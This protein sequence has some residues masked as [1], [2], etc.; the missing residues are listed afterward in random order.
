M[1]IAQHSVAGEGDAHS[2][3]AEPSALAHTCDERNL[4]YPILRAHQRALSIPTLPARAQKALSA[5]A[6]TVSANKPLASVFAHRPYLAK[7]AGISVRTWHRAENDLVDAGLI[8]VDE[9][10]RKAASGKFA[11]AYIYL[12]RATAEML[13][14]VER[15]EVPGHETQAETKPPVS[16]PSPCAT[17]A[18]RPI[19][20]FYQSPLSQKRQPGALP[21]D[22]E[23]LLEL[24]FNRNYIWKL[25]RI[26]RVEHGKLLG[27][28]VAVAGDLLRRAKHPKAY[29]WTLLRSQCDFNFL[30]KRQS[31]EAE[32]G[33]SARA[34]ADRLTALQG[35]LA[36]RVFFDRDAVTRF[37]ISAD[38]KVLTS[39]SAEEGVSRSNAANWITWFD[40]AM[41]RN[42]V[43]PATE[44]LE[45]AFEQQKRASVV[46]SMAHRP[47]T[48]NLPER[49]LNDVAAMALASLRVR[50]TALS[51]V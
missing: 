16:V 3:Q 26:A 20:R 8:T 28:V 33:T 12:V 1:V 49:R 42:E 21:K 19:Y 51:L 25:M 30:A 5:I 48:P 27:N 32:Q 47:A 13:G 44:A 45:A 35:R 18:D 50:P 36:G 6:L 23:P 40:R 14:L 46:A 9:Q 11:N 41:Q 4:P 2:H 7:R 34:E 38:A 39:R 29:L 22:V 37:E 43:R 15:E 24:G 10:T 17:V 31:T